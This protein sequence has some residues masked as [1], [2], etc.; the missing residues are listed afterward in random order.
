MFNLGEYKKRSTKL[1]DYLP[2]ASIVAPGIIL[3]KDGSF[4][5]I[6]RYRGPDLESATQSELIATSARIND[7]LKRFGSGWALSFEAER[8]EIGKD[9]KG[10]L[11]ARRLRRKASPRQRDS[12]APG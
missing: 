8:H 7:A 1:A 4:L 3:N 9:N 2:W 11:A 10:W 12:L 5:R 6:A